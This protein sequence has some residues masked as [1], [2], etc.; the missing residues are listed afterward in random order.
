MTQGNL[1]DYVN[2]KMPSLRYQMKKLAKSQI[3]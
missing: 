3:G 2:I 1:Q